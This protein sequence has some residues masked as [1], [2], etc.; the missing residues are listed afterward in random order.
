MS[1]LPTIG[2]DSPK[3]PARLA[4]LGMRLWPVLKRETWVFLEL[5]AL[6]GFVIAQP[7]LDVLGRSPDFLLF[8]QAD[9]RDIVLLAITITLL[10][11][12]ALWAVD[13]LAR[14]PGRR[15]RGIVHVVL[16]A[17]LLGLLGLEIVKKFTPLRGSALAMVGVVAAVGGGLLYAKSGALRLWLRFLSPAPIAFLLAFLLLSPAAALLKPPPAAAAA[18]PGAA[19]SGKGGPIVI[20][21]MDEFPLM[22]LLDQH[23]EIDARLYPNL[24][25][26]AKKTT[27]YRNATTNIGLTGWA[28]PSMLT[29]RYPA[30]DRLPIASQFP[31]NL[32]T[33]L[34]GTYHYK[35]HVFEGMSQL[36]PPALCE[37]A[38]TAGAGAAQGPGGFRGVL[39]AS[40]GM[41]TEMVSTHDPRQDPTATLEEGV[42]DSAAG[43]DA[44][45]T[46]TRRRAI[47]NGY[48]RGVNFARFLGSIRRPKDPNERAMYFV[49]VLIPHV[50]FKYL[51]SGLTYPE[52]SLGEGRFNFSGRWTSES[53]PVASLHQ[54]HLMQTAI[55][56]RMVGDLVKRLKKTGQYDRSLM[57]VTADH[58]M[59]FYAG[60]QARASITNTTA[61]DVLWVPLFI[62]RPG[63]RAGEISNVN[64]EHVDLVPTIADLAGIRVPWAMDGVSWANPSSSKR[65]RSQ[66]WFYPRP[67]Q[68]RVYEGPPNQA[69][70]LSKGVPEQLLRPQNGYI[71]WFQFGPHADLVGRRVSDLPVAGGGGTA[72]VVGLDDYRHI[73]PSSGVV[74]AQVGGQLKKVAPGTPARP[75]VVVALN[76]LIG[77]VSETFASPVGSA[78]T[79]F[80]AMIPDT[81]M[82]PGANRLQLFLLDTTGGRQQLRPLTLTR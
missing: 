10:P 46:S 5:F 7:V 42:V 16:I 80:T 41:W 3:S 34:G 21:L 58:G 20:L 31:N 56:D 35:M 71:G 79:W 49:H 33:L 75:P 13:A 14:L 26:L 24:A 17:A 74:P 67:G 28:L 6:A 70:A 4:S 78:P 48:K 63:Q 32:F 29:G 45:T 50:P 39:R 53:W 27:W 54:R 55:A 60:Q 73:D 82:H 37:D 44:S 69:I 40:G 1:S 36:C 2:Q 57:I 8:R 25:E 38:K 9:G 15:V 18:L 23:G 61:P 76:G 47:V 51:P 77:G 52:R 62:K 81:F 19:Q 11:G 72:S 65:T 43:P 30:Q 64:Y 22:S 12:L 66:K 68:R 59:S